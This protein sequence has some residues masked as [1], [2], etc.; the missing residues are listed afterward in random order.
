MC[1]SLFTFDLL[2]AAFVLKSFP[3][4]KV[5]LVNVVVMPRFS[6]RQR[7]SMLLLSLVIVLSLYS[8]RW[9]KTVSLILVFTLVSSVWQVWVHWSSWCIL[10]GSTMKWKFTFGENSN[11]GYDDELCHCPIESFQVTKTVRRWFC[12]GISSL[13][14]RKKIDTHSMFDSG[15]RESTLSLDRMRW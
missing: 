3:C 7:S 10:F 8:T 9:T 11:H 2:R 15:L 1:L 13:L 12:A 6:A 14:E 4:K 5:S